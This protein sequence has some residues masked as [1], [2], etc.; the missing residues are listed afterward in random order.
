MHNIADVLQVG[1]KL[2]ARMKD[3]EVQRRERAS[4]QERNRKAIAQR[5]LRER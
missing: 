4:F 5:E 3:L 1:P 2:P